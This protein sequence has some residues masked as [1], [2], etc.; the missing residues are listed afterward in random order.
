MKQHLLRLFRYDLWGNNLILNTIYSEKIK[1][2]QITIWLNH[3]LNAQNIWFDRLN[4][5]QSSIPYERMTNSEQLI[6]SFKEINDKYRQL[7]RE[8]DEAEL[9]RHHNYI[10]S[11]E[12]TYS[13]SLKDILTNVLNHSIHH[14][15]Q[16]MYRLRLLNV[17]PPDT[18]YIFYLREVERK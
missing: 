10:N 9:D 6:L 14:R 13:E 3:I 11:K 2:E 4:Y 15:A 12:I 1:D 7:I 8:S 18:D 17:T 16:I 5:G